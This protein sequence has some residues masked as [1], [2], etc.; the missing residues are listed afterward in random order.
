[1]T[2]HVQNKTTESYTRNLAHSIYTQKALQPSFADFLGPV[3]QF[4]LNIPVL[5]HVA[6]AGANI[7][8]VFCHQSVPQLEF[9]DYPQSV[10]KP[11]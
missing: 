9:L 1:M 5:D 4:S 3:V 10:N 8:Q 2:V 7:R 11:M 6:S